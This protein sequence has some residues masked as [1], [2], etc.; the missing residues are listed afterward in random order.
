MIL[1]ALTVK[2]TA[3]YGSKRTRPIQT[4]KTR[5]HQLYQRESE[6]LTRGSGFTRSKEDILSDDLSAPVLDWLWGLGMVLEKVI[7]K[8]F[9][10]CEREREPNKLSTSPPLFSLS[11][12]HHALPFYFFLGQYLS[13]HIWSNLHPSA[14]ASQALEFITHQAQLPAQS[15]QFFRSTGSSEGSKNTNKRVILIYV[16][17]S[18]SAKKII[19]STY[20][21][22]DVNI[23]P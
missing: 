9:L 13:T 23:C 1:F 2:S 22:A 16:I 10:T 7:E 6:S 19:K 18:F 3:A 20:K 14:S 12:L 5:Q 17:E 8:C 11:S 15:Y 21:Q 4:G